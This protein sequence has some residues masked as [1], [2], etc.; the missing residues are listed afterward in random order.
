[1][2]E[3][4]LPTAATILGIV[5]AVSTLIGKFLGNKNANEKKSYEDGVKETKILNKLDELSKT[6]EDMQ[7]NYATQASL[8]LLTQKVEVLEC[9]LKSFDRR[10]CNP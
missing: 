7:K 6:L 5:V 3:L 2:F 10:S 8:Q 9:S 1:M 4:N